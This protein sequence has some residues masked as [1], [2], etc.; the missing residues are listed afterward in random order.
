MPD[1][2]APIVFY[3]V[4][5]ARYY[6]CTIATLSS[7]RTFHPMS[8][9][10][11]FGECRE[12]LRAEQLDH[13]R[14]LPNV[15]YLAAADVPM[16]RVKEGWQMKAHAAHLLATQYGGTL[17]HVDSDVVL[18]AN[19]EAL[20]A[21]AAER[22]LP[23][24]GK[25][26]AGAPYPLKEYE[27]YYALTASKRDRQDYFNARYISSSVLL[28]PIQP[29]ADILPLWSAGVDDAE[30][31]PPARERKIYAGFGDQGVLNA[32]LFFKGI[33]PLELEN[34]SVS[35]HWTH[36]HKPVAFR[37]GGFWKGESRQLAFHSVGEAPKFWT[38]DYTR[39]AGSHPNLEPVYLYWL[40]QLFDGPCG[41]LTAN[42]TQGLKRKA[43]ALFPK[44]S[45]DLLGEYFR[46]RGPHLS[47]VMQ[48]FGQLSRQEHTLP[49][50]E[51]RTSENV[52]CIPVF[53]GYIDVRPDVHYFYSAVK[54]LEN[55][56]LLGGKADLV[57]IVNDEALSAFLNGT[58]LALMHQ[59]GIKVV[60][61]SSAHIRKLFFDRGIDIEAMRLGSV[62]GLKTG[63]IE[64]KYLEPLRENHNILDALEVYLGRYLLVDEIAHAWGYERCA[65]V[66]ADGG[67]YNFE[68]EE[69]PPGGHVDDIWK[70]DEFTDFVFQ[71]TITGRDEMHYV[72]P[73]G[74]R[75]LFDLRREGDFLPMFQTSGQWSQGTRHAFRRF[76][77]AMIREVQRHY[78]LGYYPGDEQVSTAIALRGEMWPP[79]GSM[80]GQSLKR[81]LQVIHGIAPTWPRPFYLRRGEGK[82][83]RH[84]LPP[85]PLE[86]RYAIC[87]CGFNRGGSRH[88]STSAFERAR[89]YREVLQGRMDVHIYTNDRELAPMPG[90]T[91]HICEPGELT[92]EWDPRAS[93]DNLMEIQHEACADEKRQAGGRFEKRPELAQGMLSKLMA[94]E[95]TLGMGYDGILSADAD[96]DQLSLETIGCLGRKHIDGMWAALRH[97]PMLCFIVGTATHDSFNT[98]LSILREASGVR[99][100]NDGPLDW[101][102]GP[103]WMMEAGFARRFFPQAKAMMRTLLDRRVTFYDEHV[104]NCTYNLAEF[105]DDP[106]RGLRDLGDAVQIGYREFNPKGLLRYKRWV[107]DA[108]HQGRKTRTRV[109]YDRPEFSYRS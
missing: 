26:G 106:M 86:G 104:L 36:G 38:A 76:C 4:T 3:T 16:G 33:T 10:W 84:F 41:L 69:L 2:S 70:F 43:G 23:G 45:P 87:I 105:D 90:V 63:K 34:D 98:W 53:N 92:T 40:F 12:P 25:D 81:Q 99:P 107:T 73:K 101:I 60:R 100:H 8:P 103:C 29:L 46:R 51:R 39:Y 58:L 24:G 80:E 22:G 6:P 83:V 68:E 64:G 27:P 95:K 109:D 78:D 77:E 5:N 7:I 50:L 102:W 93:H 89:A 35:E 47:R 9:I 32:I 18:C 97:H 21:Q 20:A 56:R 48:T 49:V 14:S 42:S 61:S 108:K 28:L 13:L 65:M 91:V 59:Y 71:E 17:I 11:V 15:H 19:F 94:V 85:P 67:R 37:E 1:L 72:S 44:E 79:F 82:Y 31:G 74:L 96:G 30:F 75:E 55:Y 52:L 54:R 62:A 66:D 88:Y 57:V